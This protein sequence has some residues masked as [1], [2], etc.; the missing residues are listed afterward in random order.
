MYGGEKISLQPE[1]YM[2]MD[3]VLKVS[4]S[5]LIDRVLNPQ[6]IDNDV[7]VINMLY[8]DSLRVKFD[9]NA[10]IRLQAL[11]VF[12]VIEGSMDLTINKADLHLS[13]CTLVDT[14]E[15]H[16]FRIKHISPDFKGYNLVVSKKFMEEVFRDTKRLPI[17]YL[18]SK[19]SNP[20][21]TLTREE[22]LLLEE[23]IQRI[24]KNLGRKEHGWYKDLV[25]NELRCFF[26]EFGNITVQQMSHSDRSSGAPNR[27]EI[28]IK[29]VHLL[30]I[31]CK[32]EHSVSFYAQRL[33]ITSAY[34]SKILKNFSGKTVNAWID[35]A[36]MRE[37]QNYLHNPNLTLQQIADALSF[38][39]QS[40]FGKFFKKHSGM[41][42]LQYRRQ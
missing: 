13:A 29:F 21:M 30:N 26:M 34:L 9:S 18:L 16:T 4:L 1:T 28:I 32:E 20:A 41:S 35:E 19:R 10:E 7:L 15:F 6:S 23:I 40:A 11:S 39:D 37:A 5:D 38:S 24:A 36:L 25:M 8:K 12:L 27:E 3:D 14:V 22:T 2:Y 17:S 33:C 31:H 42:P